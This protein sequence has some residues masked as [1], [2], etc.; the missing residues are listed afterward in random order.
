MTNGAFVVIDKHTGQVV[1]EIQNP[2]L[3]KKI[4]TDKYRSMNIYDYLVSLN[5]AIEK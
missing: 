3:L 5:K 1:R 4:N 2:A